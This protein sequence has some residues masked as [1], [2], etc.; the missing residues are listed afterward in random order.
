ML[1]Q[2]RLRARNVASFSQG[3]PAHAVTV[4]AAAVS[5]NAATQRVHM[6]Q[7]IL[8]GCCVLHGVAKCMAEGSN[9]VTE[10]HRRTG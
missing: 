1:E 4:T 6:G 7:G 2:L 3:S 9:C 5:Q 10:P 8:S